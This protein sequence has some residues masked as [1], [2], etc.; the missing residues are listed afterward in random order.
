MNLQM[1]SEIHHVYYIY[2]PALINISVSSYFVTVGLKYI[3]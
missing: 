2:Q 1:I 3:T